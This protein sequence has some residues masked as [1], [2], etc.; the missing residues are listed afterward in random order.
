[1]A[2]RAFTPPAPNLVGRTDPLVQK[3]F[4]DQA[5]QIQQLSA[6]V[7]AIPPPQPVDLKAISQ[8]LSLSGL[9]PL[10]VQGL[11]GQLSS[12]QRA[13]VAVGSSGPTSGILAQAGTLT[14]IN[15]VLSYY[16]SS[17]NPGTWRAVGAEAVVLID[18]HA[19]R[20]AKY[21][22]AKQPIGAA[23]WESD[24]KVLYLNEGT[25][26]SS[27]WTYALG[28]YNDVLANIPTLT[29]SDAGF[30]FGVSDYSHQ[31]AW[32]G[33]GW[34]W[35]PNDSRDAGQGPIPFEVDPSPTVGWHLY[36]GSGVTY[37]KSDG[38][39]G[40]VTL[41][42][43]S[44]G[45]PTQ[46]YL[47][48]GATNSGPNAPVLPTFTT[49]G[50]SFTGTPGAVTGTASTPLFLGNPA[51][52]TVASV[53]SPTFTGSAMATHQ[54]FSPIGCA[55]T[56]IVCTNV[57]GSAGSVTAVTSVVGTPTTAAFS[58]SFTSADSAGTPAGTVSAP[59][60]TMNP[61]TP[62]GTVTAPTLSMSNFTPAGTV[63]GTVTATGAGE[64]ENIVRRVWFRQ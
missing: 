6:R 29:T 3:A 22:A 49:S 14:L 12:P 23:F 58:P 11:V 38:T 1:M 51:T 39:T 25:F 63:T 56:L 18:T 2:K 28:E 15:G 42:N 60:V 24:R 64:P 30:L 33:T 57:F 19:N 13:T 46:S 9:F 45:S 36:D 53:S 21:P 20:L 40:T 44:G 59:T 48:T 50:L 27:A 41:P 8:Q 10:N 47:K 37:L 32:N 62:F 16:D 43:L 34:V 4:Q 54:H 7:S 55:S 52:P 61:Y 35:G 5:S 26:G 31:L 17:T